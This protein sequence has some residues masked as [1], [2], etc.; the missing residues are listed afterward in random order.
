[1]RLTAALQQKFYGKARGNL[2]RGKHQIPHL[3]SSKERETFVKALRQECENEMWLSRPYLN[4]Q[5]EKVLKTKYRQSSKGAPLVS[6]NKKLD[7]HMENK[8]Y[9]I[10]MLPSCLYEGQMEPFKSYGKMDRVQA[11]NKPCLQRDGRSL[12][13]QALP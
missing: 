2:T 5:Q 3:I 8:K 4:K 10:D 6:V 11:S 13:S 12:H 7:W 9:R 1:M